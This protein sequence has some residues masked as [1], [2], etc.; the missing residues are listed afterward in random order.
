L[1]L[2]AEKSNYN[3]DVLS[4]FI[5]IAVDYLMNHF[6][7]RIT[8]YNIFFYYNGE[9]I[10]VKIMPRFATSP[11]FVGYNIRFLP[12]NMNMIVDEIKKLYF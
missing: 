6:N 8:S 1:N 5:K 2:I 4:D 12:N 11:L 9:K 7:K 3:I 10:F